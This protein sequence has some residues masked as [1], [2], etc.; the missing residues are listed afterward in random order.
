MLMKTVT[1]FA[2]AAACMTTIATLPEA[3]AEAATYH[4]HS[5][6]N[7]SSW[8]PVQNIKES[9]RYDRLVATDPAFRRMRERIECGP[10]T[11]PVLHQQ[12]LD[13][14]Q[15]E[16]QAWYDGQLPAM[17]RTALNEWSNGSVAYGS[18]TPP[19]NY[20]PGSGQ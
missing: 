19:E 7:A 15:Q 12:C 5:T 16:V 1:S 18:S 4:R 11:D 14:F 17:Y 10:I 3:T 6:Y 8:S 20:T 9:E 2:F 13:G